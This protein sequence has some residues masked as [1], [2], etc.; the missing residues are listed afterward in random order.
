[1]RALAISCA[2]REFK[3]GG[4]DTL[5]KSKSHST[6]GVKPRHGENPFISMDSRN[7]AGVVGH[8]GT[9]ARRRR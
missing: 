4:A 1:V 7:K 8:G 9:V 2:P 6:P 5:P 3:G